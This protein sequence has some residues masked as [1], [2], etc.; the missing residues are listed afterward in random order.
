MI[1][2]KEWIEEIMYRP[3]HEDMPDVRSALPSQLS[4]YG[5]I[6]ANVGFLSNNQKQAIAPTAIPIDIDLPEVIQNTATTATT[7]TTTTTTITTPTQQSQPQQA[8][9]QQSQPQQQQPQQQPPSQKEQITSAPNDGSG[10]MKRGRAP[11]APRGGRGGPA[12][13]LG[14]ARG[15]PATSIG[16]AGG[17]KKRDKKKKK[18]ASKADPNDLMSA[19]RGGVKLKKGEDRK[20]KGKKNEEDTAPPKPGNL[21]ADLV[22]ALMRRRD[23]FTGE[24]DSDKNKK[25]SR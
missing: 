15:G 11:P 16:G 22:G 18:A 17:K 10:E 23:A 20:L 14:K 3:V 1:S 9:P 6:A 7:T 5:N 13:T 21:F 19:I 8:H 12:K 24:E 25:K 2:S 4:G